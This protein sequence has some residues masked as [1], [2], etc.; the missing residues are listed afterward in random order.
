VDEELFHFPLISLRYVPGEV[1]TADLDEGELLPAGKFEMPQV[2]V[3]IKYAPDIEFPVLEEDV[4][5]IGLYTLQLFEVEL[6]GVDEV[7]HP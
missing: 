1:N 4:M 2:D 6:F 3:E 7:D 5:L